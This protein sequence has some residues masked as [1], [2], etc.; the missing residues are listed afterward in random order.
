[1]DEITKIAISEMVKKYNPHTIIIYGSRA[2]GDATVESDVDIACFLDDSAAFE[3]TRNHNGIFIDA[4]DYPT[5]LM[6]DATQFIK[7]N[8]AYCAVDERGLG[9][10][11]LSKVSEE[12][13]KGLTPLNEQDKTNII[14][15]RLKILKQAC[16]GNLEGNYRK[17]WLQSDLLQTYF[18]LRRLWYFGP[19]QSFLW[20]ETNDKVAY[21][22]FSK[23]YDMPQSTEH[24]EALTSFVVNV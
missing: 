19:K 12:Y 15:L 9:K 23:V 10:K 16:K 20:L 14:E 11:L 7:F 22:L 17:F 4:W 5:E 13:K 3:D 24:L 2:R 18:L 6:N 8:Q 1:M 21:D